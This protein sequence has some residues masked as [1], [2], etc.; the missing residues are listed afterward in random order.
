MEISDMN[1]EWVA[2]MAGREVTDQEVQEFLVEWNN[3]L[4]SLDD[5]SEIYGGN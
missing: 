4:D 5:S 1:R 2:S 3:W